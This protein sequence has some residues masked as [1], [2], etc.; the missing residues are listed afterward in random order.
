M[1]LNH[2]AD[3]GVMSGAIIFIKEDL[4]ISEVQQEV[5]AGIL[6]LISLLG[7]LAGGKT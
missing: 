1:R 3:V 5:L 6:S 7:T 2:S 4:K